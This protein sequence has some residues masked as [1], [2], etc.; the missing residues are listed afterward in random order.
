M[1]RC[2]QR[3]RSERDSGRCMVWIEMS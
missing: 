3:W 1:D 2:V